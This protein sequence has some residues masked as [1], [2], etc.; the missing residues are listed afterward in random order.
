MIT[1]GTFVSLLKLSAEPTAWISP[2]ILVSLL[3]LP[4]ETI[5]WIPPGINDYSRYI[6]FIVET[7]SRT[8]AWIP[9]GIDNYICNLGGVCIRTY[10]LD[11]SR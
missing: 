6:C 4:T 7:F 2:G 1:P 9:Q 8:L 10:S 3:E 5:G 11:T